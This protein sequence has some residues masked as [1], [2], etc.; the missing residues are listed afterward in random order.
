MQIQIWTFE[1]RLWE[2]LLQKNH[3]LVPQRAIQSKFFLKNNLFLIFFIIRRTFFS[4]KE[5]FVKQTASWDVKGYMEPFRKNNSSMVLWSTFIFKSE[6]STVDHIVCA[7]FMCVNQ[8]L[9]V[10][11]SLNQICTLSVSHFQSNVRVTELVG[12]CLRAQSPLSVNK[13]S[14]WQLFRQAHSVHALQSAEL[15]FLSFK[16]VL[17]PALASVKRVRGPA[18]IFRQRFEP[19][20]CLG[21]LSRYPETPAWICSQSSHPAL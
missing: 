13:T 15:T 19:R 17:L 10:N 21:W 16:T 4:H 9:Y 12:F 1:W 3:F 5:P 18:G 14:Q 11:E 7:V 8:C 20:I 6:A 2:A